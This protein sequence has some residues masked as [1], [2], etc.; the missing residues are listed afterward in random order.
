V[1]PDWVPLATRFGAKCQQL[2]WHLSAHG[3]KQRQRELLAETEYK[4]PNAFIDLS[5]YIDVSQFKKFEKIAV[6]LNLRRI[7]KQ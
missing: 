1:P 5:F 7:I 3:S 4:K 6:F 2:C